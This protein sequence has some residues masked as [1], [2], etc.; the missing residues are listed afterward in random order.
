MYMWYIKE[1]VLPNPTAT[2]NSFDT[3]IA[4]TPIS[5]VVFH[6]KIKFS[7][8][9]NSDSIDQTCSKITDTWQY[10]ILNMLLW[11]DN[12]IIHNSKITNT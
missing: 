12:D 10:H 11:Q 3:M 7:N 9:K 4:V 8:C 6:N 1:Y 2:E 5:R